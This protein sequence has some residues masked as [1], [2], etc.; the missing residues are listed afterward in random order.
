MAKQ[1]KRGKNVTVILTCKDH[2]G[3]K[4]IYPPK[5][6][7]IACWKIYSTRMRLANKVLKIELTELKNAR[8]R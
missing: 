8:R 6:D 7:C 3:Y 5:T 4:A 1:K 2:D